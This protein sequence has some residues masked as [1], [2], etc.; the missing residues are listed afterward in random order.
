M[1]L[2]RPGTWIALLA[3]LLV[4]VPSSGESLGDA[5]RRER[6]R[7]EKLKAQGKGGAP[8]VTDEALKAHK[9]RVA[10]EPAG[11]LAGEPAAPEAAAEASASTFV[12]SP[13]RAGGM[14]D[15]E[16]RA[17]QAQFWRQAMS[18]ARQHLE[19][20]REHHDHLSRLHLV[21]RQRL[22]DRKTGK[23]VVCSVEQLREMAAEAKR[24][25]DAASRA[26]EALEER[27]RR[28]R[29]PPGWLR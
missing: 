17:R 13:P 8:L 14:D 19:Q 4:A 9:G 6:E 28:E 27:A 11:A 7:R 24:E 5:A 26:V 10:N 22:V 16:S 15:S 1:G 18:E 20:A 29:V 3:G 12:P 25:L 2:E 23:T 21:P